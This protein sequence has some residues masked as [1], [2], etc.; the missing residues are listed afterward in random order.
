[1]NGR[2]YQVLPSPN[3]LLCC[4][5]KARAQAFLASVS[6]VS[7]R[8]HLNPP[9]QFPTH[10]LRGPGAVT[11]QESHQAT[12]PRGELR[13]LA[14]ADPAPWA[15]VGLGGVREAGIIC[16]LP[17]ASCLFTCVQLHCRPGPDR[18]PMELGATGHKGQGPGTPA[19][20][21]GH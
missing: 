5:Q 17:P 21:S 3:P 9:L 20:A 6:C 8:S 13:S 7:P 10:A 18:R 2:G 11:K 4:L 15:P 1:M 12:G 16:L 19:M 14:P